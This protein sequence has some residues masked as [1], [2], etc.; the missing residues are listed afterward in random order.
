MQGN[1]EKGTRRV[2][3]L[4]VAK[5]FRE[6]GRAALQALPILLANEHMPT[7]H[8]LLQHPAINN[9]EFREYAAVQAQH[10]MRMMAQFRLLETPVLGPVFTQ[11]TPMGNMT[12]PLG[13]QEGR[14]SIMTGAVVT[15]A[16]TVAAAHNQAR[17]VDLSEGGGVPAYQPAR[18]RLADGMPLSKQPTAGTRSGCQCG[19]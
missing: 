15:Y 7:T 13:T 11:S 18:A 19:P 9:Q 1:R 3:N 12:S 10:S 14:R 8:P 4:N 16:A 5:Y 6:I 17:G 2:T